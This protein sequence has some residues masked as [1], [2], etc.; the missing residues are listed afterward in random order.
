MWKKVR[1]LVMC[2]T[3]LFPMFHAGCSSSVP[4][5]GAST[6]ELKALV[7]WNLLNQRSSV[8]LPRII[9]V[10]TGTATGSV[11]V[12]AADNLCNTD[13]SKPANSGTYMAILVTAATRVASVT[14]NV[15]DGQVN[16]VLRPNTTYTRPDG[17]V[18]M[19][20]NSA[21]IYVFGPNLTASIGT[22]GAGLWTG[23]GSN[24][25]TNVATNC[26]D[27]TSTAP[28]GIYGTANLS[29]FS[30]IA[31][32]SLGCTNPASFYCVQQ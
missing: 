26:S 12:A 28:F 2:G 7:I 17:T 8:N 19:T 5:Y 27:W 14:A 4:G 25:T 24:W 18:I 10:S 11:G 31:T 13:A 30:S 1:F 20:T 29:T 9:F 22:T 3:S 23:L 21:A 16:W 15:G 32:G 6:N